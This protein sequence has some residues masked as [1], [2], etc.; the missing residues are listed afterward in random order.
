[1]KKLNEEKLSL[2]ADYIKGY[3]KENNG[4]SPSFGRI[5]EYMNMNNSVGYRYLTALRDRGI[6]EYSG[7]S[8]LSVKGQEKMKIGFSSV[9]VLGVIPCGLPEENR[10]LIENY[11]PLPQ[12][13]CH[14]DCYLL[15]ASGD[16][17]IGAGIEDGDLV[18]IRATGTASAG[19]IAV[20]LVNG[21][22][23][24]LKRYMTDSEGRAYLHPE[25]DK[26]ADV[27]PSQLSVQGVA[28]KLIK[29]VR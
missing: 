5:I 18:L 12:E 26:Y 19:Q 23:T 14:G 16:S 15:R 13:W 9:P 4:A 29:D 28:V 10:E 6:V 3:I 8:T 11:M 27:Y 7:K 1:M 20:A 24:T 21:T 2:M 25:N 17:M 22:D